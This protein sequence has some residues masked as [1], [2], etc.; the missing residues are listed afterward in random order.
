MWNK[1]LQYIMVVFWHASQ[2]LFYHINLSGFVELQIQ[3][4]DN[5]IVEYTE[6]TVLIENKYVQVIK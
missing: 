4:D 6:Q 5:E 3:Q 1:L 2:M